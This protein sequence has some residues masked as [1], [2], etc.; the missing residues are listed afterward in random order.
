MKHINAKVT[1]HMASYISVTGS[2]HISQI[3]LLLSLLGGVKRSTAVQRE[4]SYIMSDLKK[5]SKVSYSVVNS[6]VWGAVCLFK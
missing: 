5:K 4:F 2:I 6:K 3:A 1:I